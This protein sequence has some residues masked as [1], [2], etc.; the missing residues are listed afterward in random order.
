MNTL[1]LFILLPFW[2]AI[3]IAAYS[4]PE[5]VTIQGEILHAETHMPIEGAH[6]YIHN[7][8]IGTISDEDGRFTLIA[9]P[10][11][12]LLII[13]HVGFSTRMVQA[14]SACECHD[15]IRIIL[16]PENI[17]ST[18]LLITAG[19]MQMQHGGVYSSS[20]TKSVDDHMASIPGLDMVTR[21][22]MAKDPVIR[23]LRDGRVNVMIDGMRL[24]PACVD[25]MDPATAYIETDNLQAIEIS[26]GF[27]NGTKNQSAP[28]GSVN[29]SMV[30]P[31][32]NSGISAS[33]E[34]GYQSASMQ[35]L[36]QGSTSYG[37]EIWAIRLSG[38]YRDAGDLL[39]GAG[40]RIS[41]SGFNKGNMMASAL[42]V[43]SESHR[44]NLRYIGDFA[45]K[46][47][48]PNLIMDTRRAD[49]HIAGLE[50]S[51]QQPF[52][53][54]QSITTNLY[55]NRVQHWMD[56]YSRDVTQREV[57][58]NMYMPMYGETTTSGLTSEL[59]A[60]RNNHLFNASVEVFRINAFADMLME[61]IDPR[62]RD[63]YL[64]NVGDVV[65]QNVAIS[66]SHTRF[67]DTGWLIRTALRAEIGMNQLN[68]PDARATYRAEYSTNIN[69]KPTDAGVMASFSAERQ[70]AS[71]LLAG[72]GL[73]TG[74]RL[75]GHLE[76]YGY[77]IY[78]PLDGYFYIG[79]P[80]LKPERSSQAEIFTRIGN[81]DSRFGGSL[82]L[83]I[84][85]MGRYMAGIQV[86]ELFKHMQN[87]G[88]AVL[89]G[90]EADLSVHLH[91]NWTASGALSYVHGTHNELDEPLPM[92]PPLKGHLSLQ[93]R[94]DR[95]QV[96]GRLRWSA[97]QNRIAT[98]NSNET[99]TGGYALLDIHSSV[100]ISSAVSVRIGIDNILNTFHTEHLSVNAMPA[101]GRNVLLSVRMGLN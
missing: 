2:F 81:D 85:R 82:T 62:V 38:T 51:W 88:T 79:N 44:I 93:R 73:S 89:T 27:E 22:N 97:S 74:T 34:T 28:G 3:P 21:A 42:Y 15:M 72:V 61:H 4:A 19:R 5:T 86:D 67:A 55:I 29:F 47:G 84:N 77:Y 101:P 49:A 70:L 43:P 48:Y 9:E 52:R 20:N 33:A 26:R 66:G 45:G 65:Q 35:Q 8:D 75:P 60:S 40:N 36:Y 94:S 37:G 54:I 78:Q 12:H 71:R 14:H 6:I 99:K 17:R 16:E 30:R 90:F 53:G 95:L 100:P 59:T 32:L 7:T 31:T 23:G 92:I 18:E 39:H 98:L 64:V 41:G 58:R 56:D 68:H 50:H 25:G 46:I 1:K 10:G 57:M 69:L 13:S 76:R 87:M 11:H 24:T 63:M 91:Q 83:W 80:E 96:E